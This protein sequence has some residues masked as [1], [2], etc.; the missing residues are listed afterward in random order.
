MKNYS[1]NTGH[2]RE[3][4]EKELEKEQKRL[5]AGQVFLKFL[6]QSHFILKSYRLDN[7]LKTL[8]K[9]KSKPQTAKG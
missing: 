8:L 4:L 1:L 3:N 5:Q 6:I 7:C 9:S 2:H